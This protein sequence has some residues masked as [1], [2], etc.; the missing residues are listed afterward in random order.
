MAKGSK[1]L[2]AHKIDAASLELETSNYPHQGEQSRF[3]SIEGLVEQ[4]TKA[5]LAP[6]VEPLK[7]YEAGLLLTFKNEFTQAQELLD[8]AYRHFLGTKNFLDAIRCLIE[9]AWIKHRQGGDEAVT[10]ANR[11]FTEA[12]SMIRAHINDSGI[13]DLR[14]RLLHYRGL[15]H[16]REGNFGEG[17][18]NFKIAKT[19]ASPDGLESAKILDSFGIYYERTGD[20]QRAI[21]SLKSSLSLKEKMHIAYEEAIT[22]QILGRIYVTNEE[23]HLGH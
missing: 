8:Q 18:R 13:N 7:L 14:A 6:P 22:R 12:E 20:L 15:I 2:D 11:L 23:F 4:D 16:Y 5:R 10:K 19:Y 21:S 1:K 3:S 17:V 9:M